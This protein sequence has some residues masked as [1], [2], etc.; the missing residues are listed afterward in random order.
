MCMNMNVKT[1]DKF[2]LEEIY[3]R[4]LNDKRFFLM[5]DIII[6]HGS[7]CYI[8]TFKVARLAIKKALRRKDIDLKAVLLGA[9]L[10]DYYLYDRHKPGQEI[11]HHMSVHPY[12][13]SKKAKEDFGIDDKVAHIIESHMWP[14]NFKNFPKSKEARLVSFSDKIVSTIEMM[15]SKKFKKRR[16]EK[17]L[18]EISTLFD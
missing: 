2:E 14:F 16:E 10:H 4:F 5:K 13:A 6:H 9:I 15:S 18:K 17:Y 11:S 1:Q 12:I 7:N 8:H 3:Q